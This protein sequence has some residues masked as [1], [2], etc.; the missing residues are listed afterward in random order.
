MLRLFT[1]FY[2]YMNTALNVGVAQ[3]MGANTAKKR[4]KLAVDYAMLYVAP[5]VLGYALKNALTPGDSGDDEFD[6][7]ARTLAGEQLTFLLGLMVVTREFGEVGKIVTGNYGFDYQGPAG[8]RL[9]SDSQ[10]AAQQAMQGEFD[11]AFRKA[12][13]NLLGSLTGLPSTQINKSITG[14]Q[15]LNE[16]KTNNPA[17]L[18]F[19]YQE[20]R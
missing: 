16:G 19:G 2:M 20:P 5:A 3:T 7:I 4:A 14:A 8:V 18:I 17:A 9:V 13:I 1:V 11:D 10:K 12:S 6:E 15:A